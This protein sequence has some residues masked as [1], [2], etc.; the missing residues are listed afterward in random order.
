MLLIH[1]SKE[2]E[3]QYLPEQNDHVHD[4]EI[5]ICQGDQHNLLFNMLGLN[6]SN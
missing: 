2:I 1:F 4:L 6:V 5:V 3:I